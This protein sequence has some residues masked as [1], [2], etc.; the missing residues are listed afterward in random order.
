MPSSYRRYA[1]DYDGDGAIDLLGS[2]ADAIGSIASYMKAFGWVAGE[3]PTAPVRLASGS[4]AG[5]SSADSIAS[6]TC[7]KCKAK[8][9]CSRAGIRRPACVRSSSYRRPANLPSSW[10]ASTTSKS[11]RATTARRS[12]PPRCSS[13]GKPSTKAHGQ[14]AARVGSSAHRDGVHRRRL[15]RCGSL[16]SILAVVAAPIQRL[17]EQITFAQPRQGA[18]QGRAVIMRRNGPVQRFKMSSLRFSQS[19]V[20]AYQPVVSLVTFDG[21][22]LTKHRQTALT[23]KALSIG[24]NAKC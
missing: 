12:M 8:A 11:S 22:C 7:R 6:T 17:G 14:R 13:S 24:G 1:V 3:A 4:E 9:W 16:T 20:V 21:S 5:I 15:E 10:R 23:N 18:L 19:R 2:P